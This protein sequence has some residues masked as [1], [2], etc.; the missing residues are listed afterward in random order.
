MGWSYLY[1]AQCPPNDSKSMDVSPVFRFINN[2]IVELKD[3][4]PHFL[5]FKGKVYKDQC[6]AKG[7][8]VYSSYYSMLDLQNK[9]PA[10]RDKKIAIGKIAND[11]GKVLVG[12]KSHITWWIESNNPHLN[13]SVYNDE[14]A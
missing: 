3:F 2:S 8:S 13:F 6:L 5:K 12:E 4:E 10:F 7:T 11:D 14:Q 9:I 1:D